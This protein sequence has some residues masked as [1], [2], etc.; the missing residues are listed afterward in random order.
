MYRHNRFEFNVVK[1]ADHDD[2][3]DNDTIIIIEI[4]I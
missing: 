1:D 4:M 2:S 3:Q